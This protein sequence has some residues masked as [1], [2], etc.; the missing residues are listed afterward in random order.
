MK[1]LFRSVV[2]IAMV[3]T[4]SIPVMGEPQMKQSIKTGFADVAINIALPE[5]TGMTLDNPTG[6]VV[7]SSMFESAQ[8]DFWGEDIQGTTLTYDGK[9]IVGKVPMELS[10]QWFNIILTDKATQMNMNLL[11]LL[12]QEKANVIDIKVIEAEPHI[13]ISSNLA[14]YNALNWQDWYTL[15]AIAQF[16]SNKPAYE[17]PMQWLPNSAYE[18]WKTADK[19]YWGKMYPDRMKYIIEFSNC[20]DLYDNAPAWV[21]NSSK[22][23]FAANYAMSYVKIA[24]E[25]NNL[26]IAEPPI[27][28]YSFLN[29]IDF[30]NEFLTHFPMQPQKVML[31]KILNISA[32]DI[33]A[34][35]EIPVKEWQAT[36]RKALSKAFEPT[37]LLLDM[38]AAQSYINQISEQNKPLTAKQID[39]VKNGFNNDLGKI[40]LDRNEKK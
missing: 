17:D 16:I 35:G 30:G 19:E 38:M 26:T 1:Q 7:N 12:S 29:K 34:I 2:L 5:N 27:E 40:I 20:S 21:K 13:S 24:K 23:W 10:Y 36:V 32:A 25:M 33:K 9:S 37:D 3:L 18:N 6:L 15:S 14:V 39:N 31:D 8:K 4:M 28:F 11:V 22:W